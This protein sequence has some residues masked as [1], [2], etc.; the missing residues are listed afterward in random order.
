MHLL[1]KE[2]SGHNQI[3]VFETTHLYGEQGK[4]RC[5]QFADEDIQGAIDLKSPLRVVLSYQRA[6]IH[7]MELN[8]PMFDHVFVI[9][10][11]I[12]TIAGYYPKKQIIV[13]EIDEKVVELSKLYFGYQK[14]NVIIGDGLEI[15]QNERSHVY[16][17][18][19]LDAFTYKGTPLHLIT[20]EFFNMTKEKLTTKGA[21]ILNLMGK[22]K[23]DRLLNAIHTTLREAYKY[24]K[25]YTLH[26]E[27]ETDTRNIIVMG[28]NQSIDLESHDLHGF[29]EIE[30]GQGHVIRQ[31]D[32][33][34]SP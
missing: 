27:N 22:P 28:S 30:L 4:F 24:S 34:K 17:Y 10:H 26:A 14:D 12:G 6:L 15:L 19:V 21:V 31:M 16:D 25:A 32:L 33:K 23:N 29:S 11:G 13:A 9:G 7:L 8:N 1:A 20:L 5:M 2:V 18:I 3:T